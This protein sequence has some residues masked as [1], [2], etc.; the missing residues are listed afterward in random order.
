M[1]RRHVSSSVVIPI[2]TRSRNDI[3]S[4][5]KKTEKKE[6]VARNQRMLNNLLFGTLDK[7]RR[8]VKT[9]T[10]AANAQQKK[11]MEIDERLEKTKEEA[12][13]RIYQEKQEMF[14]KRREEE[15]EVKK[16]RRLKAIELGA[17]DKEEH[18][19]RLQRFIQTSAKPPIFYL[20][21]KH[22]PETEELLEQS[23]KSIEGLIE[24]LR[25]DSEKQM[26]GGDSSDG[27]PQ[28]NRLASRVVTANDDNEET[29][30][31]EHENENESSKEDGDEDKDDSPNGI[32]I[33]YE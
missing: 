20:P 17:K 10:P 15:V 23:S 13:E 7:F 29:P 18:F 26:N 6:D 21:V 8:E 4:D 28:S 30:P 19:R 3:I 2:E 27:E 1:K 31:K 5:I 11:L 14:A 22:T 25:E 32:H 33:E 16:Q 9:A 12:R 24:K